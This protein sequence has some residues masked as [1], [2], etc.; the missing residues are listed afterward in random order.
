MT[1]A[2]P[3]RWL[4]V[5]KRVSEF[6]MLLGGGKVSQALLRTRAADDAV[7]ECQGVSEQAR[8]AWRSHLSQATFHAADEMQFRRFQDLLRVSATRHREGADTAREELHD[9]QAALRTVLAEKGALQAAI[10]RANDRSKVQLA[11]RGQRE[12]DEAWAGADHDGSHR[13]DR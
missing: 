3:T 9:A 10:S 4:Q 11:Q 7:R 8:E 1:E 13:A 6:R 5:A 2:K 12:T